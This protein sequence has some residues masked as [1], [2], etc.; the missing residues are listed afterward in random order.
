MTLFSKAIFNDEPAKGWL[1][2]GVFAPILT[3]FLFNLALIGVMIG[4]M[5]PLGFVDE[6]IDPSG[7]IGMAFMLFG[8]FGFAGFLFFL[9]V[10]FVER[11]PFSSVG[12]RG[13]N[14]LAIFVR[15]H[16]TGIGLMLVIVAGIWAFGGYQMGSIAPALASPVGLFHIAL[17][18]VGFAV[19]SSIEEFVFRGWLLSAL[20][21]KFNLLTAILVSSILFM[22]MH[23]D[24]S[25][26]FFDNLMTILF[27]FFACA[28]V[29][30][31]GNIW[32]VMGWHAGWNWITATGFE[33]PVTGLV[34]DTP[35]LLVQL[36][37]VGSDILTG[38]KMGPEGSIVTSIV[39][40][41]ATLWLL[42]LLDNAPVIRENTPLGAN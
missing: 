35:A 19:Q 37:P 26:P 4:I 25:N 14:A 27:S 10:K 42:R 22:L 30:K 11:R 31:T 5:K 38:G 29:I 33:L 23:F 9:W 2:W 40:I 39:L 16:L 36:T 32:G 1:P 21:R 3:F 34:T 7:P 28:W 24:P 13:A 12:L 41:L 15:G 17:L 6:N 18:L 20:T 8:A